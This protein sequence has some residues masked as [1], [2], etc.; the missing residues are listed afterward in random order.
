M[1]AVRKNGGGCHLGSPNA[2]VYWWF[3][4][5]TDDEQKSQLGGISCYI[6]N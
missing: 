2:A 5:V 1:Y 6:S 4:V 3:N